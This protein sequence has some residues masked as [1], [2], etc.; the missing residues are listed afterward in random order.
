VLDDTARDQTKL[1]D[2]GR[3][4]RPVRCSRCN[5]ALTHDRERIDVD[6]AH[7]HTFV[8]PSGVVFRI[9]MFR[10]VDGAVVHGDPEKFTSWFAGTAWQF[11]SCAQCAGHLGW[12][13]VRVD[14][15]SAGERFFGLIEDC[16][17]V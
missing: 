8:N 7:A 10:A 6:G 4:E 14:E 2:E 17:T 13:Y 1:D 3:A 16:I 12:A 9:V 15:P 5:H 11:A